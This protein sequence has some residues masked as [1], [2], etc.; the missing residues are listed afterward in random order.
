MNE[1]AKSHH[2]KSHVLSAWKLVADNSSCLVI[3][4][5]DGIMLMLH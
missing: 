3:K 5:P 1:L 4:Q 2:N